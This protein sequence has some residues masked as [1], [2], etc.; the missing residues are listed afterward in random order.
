MHFFSIAQIKGISVGLFPP[1]ET[2][3]HVTGTAVVPCYVL[4]TPI[5]KQ[6]LLWDQSSQKLNFLFTI[7]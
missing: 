1:E 2:S 7:C 4:P 6:L 5:T 3:S